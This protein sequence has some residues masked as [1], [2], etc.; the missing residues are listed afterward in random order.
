MC[1][2]HQFRED[3]HPQ[4]FKCVRCD[5]RLLSAEALFKIILCAIGFGFVVGMGMIVISIQ[6]RHLYLF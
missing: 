2:C 5:A 1:S 3:G 4:F 6:L